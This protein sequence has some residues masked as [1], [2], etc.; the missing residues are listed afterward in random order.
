MELTAGSVVLSKAGRDKGKFLAVIQV[1]D[2]DVLLCDGKERPL[3]NPK[4]KNIRHIAITSSVLSQDEMSSNRSLRKALSR[5][6]DAVQ[7]SI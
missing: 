5:F 1:F 6:N 7:K 2:G 4:R 3:N